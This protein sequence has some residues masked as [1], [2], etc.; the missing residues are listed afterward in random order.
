MFLYIFIHFKSCFF[1]HFFPFL[2][3]SFFSIHHT[4]GHCWAMIGSPF[5]PSASKAINK[6]LGSCP[7]F[8]CLVSWWKQHL[9]L[10][11]PDHFVCI[12]MSWLM[13]ASMHVVIWHLANNFLLCLSLFL[14]QKINL[15]KG[16]KMRNSNDCLLLMSSLELS[17]QTFQVTW[18]TF[19]VVKIE[20]LLLN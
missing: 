10:S 16:G 13:T 6:A 11:L 20:L 5:T 19:K 12:F 18:K 2:A 7:D 17:A 15:K 14:T 4:P 8:F 1:L 3:F 9:I